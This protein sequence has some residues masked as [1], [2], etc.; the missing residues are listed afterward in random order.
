MIK[1]SLGIDIS[2][3]D[4]H[5]CMSVIEE[6]QQVK[7]K[8]STKFPNTLTGFGNLK[9]WIKKYHVVSNKPLVIVMEATGVYYEECALY[10][11]KAGYY[12]SVILPNK[13]K[14]YMQAL[15]LKTK[16]DKID[17]QG[18]S[19]MA[20]EQ[21]LEQWQPMSEF[22]FTLRAYTRQL[23]NLQEM[24]TSIGNQLHAAELTMYKVKKVIKQ[25][26][27][28]IKRIDQDIAALG[29]VIDKH[30]AADKL[31]AEKVEKICTIKG[32]G[33]LTV[34]VILAETNGFGLFESIAQLVNY[35]G[36]DVTENESGK[37]KGKTRISK[38]GNSRIRRILHMPAFNVVR[39]KVPGFIGIFE[40]TYERHH[41]KMKSYVAVQKRILKIIYTLWKNN[42][43][44]DYKL[45]NNKTNADVEQ[46]LPLG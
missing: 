10:L 43:P 11:H 40:R 16:N 21:A 3:K 41:I 19:R 39:Y 17:A 12:V 33:K 35:T 36:Y 14:K 18:L 5:V 13:A 6:H 9:E 29:K 2:Y 4:F 20:A 27:D 30:L 28:M 37:R 42:K 25:L 31:V 7:V 45:I 23:Q 15:G 32:V 34:A 26:K 46:V 44:Y 1:Y 24:K 22:F 8:G 38:K